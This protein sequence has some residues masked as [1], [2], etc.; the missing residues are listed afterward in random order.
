MS[1]RRIRSTIMGCVSLVLI[2]TLVL[3]IFPVT[4]Q[5]SNPA[6]IKNELE[7]LQDRADEIDRQ[8]AE[9]QQ[10][11]DDNTLQIESIID[12]KKVLD[13]QIRL[14]YEEIENINAQIQ[15]YNQL[16]ADQQKNLD[17]ALKRQKDLTAQYSTRIRAMEKNS[18]ISYW[19]VLFQS[20]SFSDFLGNLQMMSDVAQADQKMMEELCAAALEI[21][22]AQDQL[23]AEKTSLDNQRTALAENQAALDLMNAEANLLLD[24]LNDSTS[25]ILDLMAEYEREEAELNEEVAELEREYTNAIEA[26]Q[27]PGGTSSG[28]LY[29]LPYRVSITD[30]YGWRHHVITGKYSFHH[31]VDF[32]AGRGTK[33]YAARSGTVTEAVADDRIYGNYVTI[34]HGDGY[35]SLY[36]HMTHFVV[37]Q[38]DYV[39]Q[40]QVIGYVGSSGWS[41]GP[42]LHFSIYYN[43]SSVNP[44]NYVG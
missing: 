9:L 22:N 11:I 41:S 44:M 38:G 23:S 18:H 4:G 32:A 29:P 39:T 36:A 20:T 37:S 33:I 17:D 15:I 8:Q 3:N 30:A 1:I 42:H 12:Q 19:S 2:F 35:S 40:G 27:V 6:S 10:Q 28:W 31:G 24:A 16:I 21:R 13:Q 14:I 7:T 34:N 25:E 5:A 43:G 26:G